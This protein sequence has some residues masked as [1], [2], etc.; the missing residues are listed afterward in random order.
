MN[1]LMIY[2]SSLWRKTLKDVES[3]SPRRHSAAERAAFA[4]S[5][6]RGPRTKSPFRAAS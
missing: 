3:H 4:R 5:L 1:I 2:W 6:R